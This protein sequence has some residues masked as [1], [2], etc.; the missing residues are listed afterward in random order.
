MLKQEKWFFFAKSL[1]A[2]VNH[3]W[4]SA[5][6]FGL[7]SHLNKIFKIGAEMKKNIPLFTAVILL[8]NFQSLSAQITYSSP[9]DSTIVIYPGQVIKYYYTYNSNGSPTEDE[10]VYFVDNEIS[11][12]WR[13]VYEYDE[14]NNK[15]LKLRQKQDSTGWGN[16][17]KIEY[18]YDTNNNL[19]FE[20][21]Q[22]WV[23]S[24][25]VDTDRRT[26]EYNT[27]G[28]P[29]TEIFEYWFID[30]WNLDYRLDREYNEN[31]LLSMLTEV[32]EF[33][34]S[35]FNSK[36]DTFAYDSDGNLLEQIEQRYADS[37]W[38][39]YKQYLHKYSNG[40][41]DTTTF[42]WWEDTF[43][44]PFDR[45]I[46]TY[47][48]NKDKTHETVQLFQDSAWVNRSQDTWVYSQLN[49]VEEY[50]TSY[51]V[52]EAWDK[53]AGYVYE[54]DSEGN[55][56]FQQIGNWENGAY[57]SEGLIAPLTLK[58]S[59]DLEFV[60]SGTSFTAFFSS[61]VTSVNESE[62]IPVN[63]KLEQNYPNPFNPTTRIKYQVSSNENVTIKVFDSIGREV[64]TLISKQLQPGVYEVDFNASAFSSGIYFY[65]IQAG[66]FVQTK[67]MLLI[68]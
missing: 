68:K 9:P 43:W 15:T 45:T 38:A 62:F 8:L 20:F 4:T 61:S 54:Y 21:E 39:P 53:D 34:G 3:K 51:W 22:F 57:S 59:D 47:N 67:K 44:D 32:T 12:S 52:S 48:N 13:T 46:F 24:V 63:F 49:K 50:F 23:D 27:E 26:I 18:E 7:N 28:K 42:S 60:Y 35:L 11:Q 1:P 41:L 36:R 6:S 66:D 37:V 55:N 5:D 30:K 58:V 17:D 19:I 14:N 16:Y 10:S 56:I 2:E 64:T 25:W 65:M 33:L 31:G 40:M 29:I